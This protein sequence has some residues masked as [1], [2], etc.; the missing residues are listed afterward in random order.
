MNGNWGCEE[1]GLSMEFWA[2]CILKWKVG[3]SV[4]L[5]FKRSD[6]LH[7]GNKYS[8]HRMNSIPRQ[9]E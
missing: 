2:S 6:A 4:D 5:E 7:S 9:S 1:F 3:A 8:E